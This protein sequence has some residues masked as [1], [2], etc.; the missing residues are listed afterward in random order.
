SAG[1]LFLGKKRPASRRRDSQY[2]KKIQGNVSGLNGFRFPRHLQA[3]A[4]RVIRG[5]GLQGAGLLLN[6]REF[7]K[8]ASGERDQSVGVRIRKRLQKHGVNG[9]EDGGVGA[10]AERKR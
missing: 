8:R 10:N 2:T 1:L 6:L 3:G 4:K 5:G 9:A 7:G